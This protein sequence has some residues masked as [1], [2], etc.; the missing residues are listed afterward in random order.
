[1]K[2]VILSIPSRSRP[3][4]ARQRQSAEVF[5]RRY[6]STLIFTLFFTAGIIW[7]AVVSVK[8]EA[9]FLSDMDFLFT[10]NL[11]SRLSQ[12]MLS[13]FAA[14]FAS[15][16]IFFTAAALCGLSP[17]GVGVLPFIVAFKGFGTGLSAAYLISAY[18]V[19]GLGFYIVVVLPG[20]F[21]F[22]LALLFMSAHCASMSLRLARLLF[23]KGEGAVPVT[24]YVK[25][26]LFRCSYY[27]LFS[28]VGAVCD[29]LFW[30]FVSGLFF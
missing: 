13:S 8:A 30:S 2:G 29:M 17:W 14:H 16:F 26:Y 25:N 28:A 11:R 3:K 5:L 19:K 6:L 4:I 15:N 10:T 1:M 7:G 18:G 23:V 20:T 12:G 21:L 27:L 9:D 24:V 22:S